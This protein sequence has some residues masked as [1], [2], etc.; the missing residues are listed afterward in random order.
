MPRLRIGLTGGIGAGKSSVASLLA[1]HGAVVIDAD[2]LAREAV[3]PGTPGLE[4]VVSRFGRSVLSPDGSLDR[5]ALGRVVFADQTARADLN[6][7]VHPEVRRLAAA[8]ESAAPADAVIVQVI[9]LLVETGQSNDFDAVVVVDAPEHVQLA[10]VMGRDGIDAAAAQARLDAQAARDERLAA[11][12]HVVDNSDDP[13]AL[14]FRV[15]ALWH[16]LV[17]GETAPGA[18]IPDASGGPVGACNDSA[19]PPIVGGGN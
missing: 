11:A 1:E 3:A 12:T 19:E 14:R 16:R 9:P 8:R 5:A 13:E 10:R 17:A 2:R 18:A 15:D 6:A 7:I 4:A